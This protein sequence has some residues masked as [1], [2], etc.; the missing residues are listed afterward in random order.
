MKRNALWIMLACGALCSLVSSCSK[1]NKNQWDESKSS[2]SYKYKNSQSLWGNDGQ[3]SAT[4]HD[5]DGPIAEDFIPLRDEDLKSQFADNA[6][7]QPRHDL[8]EPGSGIPGIDQ[9]QSPSSELSALFR[10]LY[11]NTDESAV[12][13]KD[14]LAAIDRI[15]SY[16][17]DHPRT[18]IVIEGHCDE[19]GPEA[20]NLSLGA[21]RANSVRALLIKNGVDLN[22]IHTISYGKERPVE[23]GHGPEAWSKNRR[24]QFKISQ[25]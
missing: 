1:K 24:A 20:Y 19:R 4:E 23:L 2:A 12:R 18:Y 9:F 16:L 5:L 6:I 14:A 11:F 25:R 15:A 10:T 8:G 7:P 21:R 3:D 13:G 17:K 22:Q